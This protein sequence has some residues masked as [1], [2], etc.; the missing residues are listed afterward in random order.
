MSSWFGEGKGRD[1]ES[2]EGKQRWVAVRGKDIE[3]G[4]RCG[5]KGKVTN[6]KG[7]SGETDGATNGKGRGR[8]RGREATTT[9]G[10]H[11]VVVKFFSIA[12][13]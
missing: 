2:R 5:R 4:H 8:G 9:L 1:S 11:I 6:E 12:C 3:E 7:R 13:I 10:I